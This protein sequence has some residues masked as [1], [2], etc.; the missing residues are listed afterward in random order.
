MPSKKIYNC[1]IAE[2]FINHSDYIDDLVYCNG[3]DTFY[4]WNRDHYDMV[5][6]RDMQIDAR[7]F[8]RHKFSNID[9][10]MAV[11][12]DIIA[13]IKLITVR[14]TE[15]PDNSYAAFR[16]R[17]I[18]LETFE[19]VPTNKDLIVDF[20]LPYLWE[21]V[22]N[23]KTPHFDKFLKT[24]LVR[25]KNTS[26]TDMELIYFVQE[27][28]G[29]FL[30]AN[31]TGAGAFFLVGQGAN[32]KSIM[33]YILQEM[34][35]IKYYTSMSIQDLTMDK[36]ATVNLIGKKINISNEEESKY[37]KS[38]KF[39]A[40]VTGDPIKVERKFSD[41]F[42]YLPTTKYIFASNELPTFDGL[43]Y[44]I[45]RR[46]KIIPFFRKFKDSDEDKIP[47]HILKSHLRTEMP[48]IIRWA[49]NGAKRFVSNNYIFTTASASLNELIEFENEVSSSLRYVRENYIVVEKGAGFIS[50][51][52]I[53]DRYKDWCTKNGKKYVS[54]ARFSKEIIA[55]IDGIESYTERYKNTTSRGK[56]LIPK[57]EAEPIPVT[58]GLD[59]IF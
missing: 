13:Q 6:E 1:E 27:M 30:L 57:D 4:M 21:E 42:T 16:D 47:E 37:L 53:Y 44:G 14:Q 41:G 35:T 40:L 10:K 23:T 15:K 43:N 17:Y 28:F 36:F 19:T 45:K 3:Y 51:D 59:K 39:K 58:G 33:T 5:K 46:M 11:L 56:N 52:E 49:I 7:K 29:F 34:F 2:E 20:Y 26:V 24:S 9:T 31:L 50:N 32:G 54:S 48:G 25:R 55:N 8:I 22:L 12:N 38:D 18:N